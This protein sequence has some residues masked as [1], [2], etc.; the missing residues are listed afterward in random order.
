MFPLDDFPAVFSETFVMIEALQLN[1]KAE[2]CAVR[3]S[4]NHVAV[5]FDLTTLD[6]V[7]RARITQAI[8]QAIW[9][10]TKVPAHNGSSLKI[11]GQVFNKSERQTC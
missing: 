7:R 9:R 11:P 6:V 4:V 2:Y 10:N 8:D 5:W 1:N 3:V